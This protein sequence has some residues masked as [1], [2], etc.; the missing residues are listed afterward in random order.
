MI[1]LDANVLIRYFAK[2]DPVQTPKSIALIHSLSPQRPGYVPLVALAETAWVMARSYAVRR[3][4][5][6][7]IVSTMI[8]SEDLVPESAEA[9]ATALRLFQITTIGFSDCLIVRSGQA[10]R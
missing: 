7:R 3:V 6:A 2:D 5:L 1:G 4:V 9:V 8:D 10:A